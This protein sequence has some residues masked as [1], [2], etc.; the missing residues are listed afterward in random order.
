MGDQVGT[1]WLTDTG[2]DSRNRLWGSR[3]ELEFPK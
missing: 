1:A 3:E 2:E